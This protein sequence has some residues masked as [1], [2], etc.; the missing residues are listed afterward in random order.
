MERDYELKLSCLLR[1]ILFIISFYTT[2]LSFTSYIYYYSYISIEKTSEWFFKNWNIITQ[3]IDKNTNE[4]NYVK[5]FLNNLRNEK[6]EY[7]D[8]KL[9][10]S[11]FMNKDQFKEY[12]DEYYYFVYTKYLEDNINWIIIEKYTGTSSGFEI[13]MK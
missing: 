8:K 9:N 11:F 4:N 1:V 10:N 12:V 7:I 3:K 5:N 13:S 2:W 6:L